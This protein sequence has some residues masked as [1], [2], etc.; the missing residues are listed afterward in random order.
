M[1]SSTAVGPPAPMVIHREGSI[2]VGSH[3]PQLSSQFPSS[4]QRG[5]SAH[6]SQ[7][8][9]VEAKHVALFRLAEH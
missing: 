4:P 3:A 2:V 5:G 9:P 7:T 6:D 8:Q 1:I